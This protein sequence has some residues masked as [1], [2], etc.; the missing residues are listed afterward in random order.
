M[1]GSISVNDC[2]KWS[3]KLYLKGKVF[4]IYS[5]RPMLT[6]LLCLNNGGVH[7]VP[8]RDIELAGW[9]IGSKESLGLNMAE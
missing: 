5:L 8:G 2:T 7:S 9:R 4:M 1:H 6:V 3:C